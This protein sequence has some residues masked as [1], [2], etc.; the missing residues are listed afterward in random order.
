[1][2]SNKLTLHTEEKMIDEQ[3]KQIIKDAIDKHFEKESLYWKAKRAAMFSNA[4]AIP[5]LF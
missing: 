3:A 2:S 4:K 1:M 5:K